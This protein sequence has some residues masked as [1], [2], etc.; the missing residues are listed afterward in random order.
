LVIAGR[1]DFVL[2]TLLKR[3]ASGR[4]VAGSKRIRLDSVSGSVRRYARGMVKQGGTCNI[5]ERGKLV[6]LRMPAIFEWFAGK[7]VTSGP[8]RFSVLTE[9]Q[10]IITVV[11]KV[12]DCILGTLYTV[13]TF[14][15]PSCAANTFE[16]SVL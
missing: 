6:V 4:A 11:T 16:V 3:T 2:Q 14:S 1:L 10:N 9:A 8:P 12:R 5:V 7:S 15:P 13:Q